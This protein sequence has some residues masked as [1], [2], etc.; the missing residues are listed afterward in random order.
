MK[1]KANFLYLLY[2][3]FPLHQSANSFRTEIL[4]NS[5][6][7]KFQVAATTF[8]F[9]LLTTVHMLS[10]ALFIHRLSIKGTLGQV[11]AIFDAKAEGEDGETPRKRVS[12]ELV[13]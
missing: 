6:R 1:V 7:M 2:M 5:W 3:N 11:G 13:P 10:F 8:F 4:V 9:C 12:R